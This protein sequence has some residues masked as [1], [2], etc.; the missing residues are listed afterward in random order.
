MLGGSGGRRARGGIPGL[1]SGSGGRSAPGTRAP[2]DDRGGAPLGFR[3]HRGDFPV[4]V[5]EPPTVAPKELQSLREELDR[6]A[7]VLLETDI[8]EIPE[9]ELPWGAEDA[10]RETVLPFTQQSKAA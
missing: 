5:E 8:P 1:L 6:L 4:A 9:G 10:D 2:V 3:R 7:T